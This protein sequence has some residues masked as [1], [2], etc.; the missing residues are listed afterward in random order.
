MSVI[1]KGKLKK[2]VEHHTR[3]FKDVMSGKLSHHETACYR[4]AKFKGR[5]SGEP[6]QNF[7]FPNSNEIDVLKFVDTQVK[8]GQR[9]TYVVYAYELVVGTKYRYESVVATGEGAVVQVTVAPSLKM[10]ETP[11]FSKNVLMIDSPPVHPDVEMVPYRAVNDRVRIQLNGNVGKYEMK[12]EKINEG[13]FVEEKKHL[14]AQ[15]K[16]L[17]E[18]IEY[19]GDDP[20]KAFQIWRMTKKPRKYSDFDGHLIKTVRTGDGYFHASS[21]T[22]VDKIEPNTK[23]YYTFRS[24][25]VHGNISY[26]TPIY[27]YEMIDDSG[28]VYPVMQVVPIS[29]TEQRQKSKAGKRFIRIYPSFGNT[30][31][32]L[33]ELDGVATAGDVRAVPLGIQE[34]KTWGKKFKIRIKSKNTGKQVDFNV[35]FEHKHV[36]D[37]KSV[38]GGR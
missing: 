3:S 15:S 19:Q 8:Y 13:D 30:L 29:L 12:P 7:Y 2:I 35:S 33:S 22:F 38:K 18:K 11:Y 17:G 14:M 6:I 27:E 20:P 23:Y 36:K 37:I 9:Y 21:A 25:D 1:L 34:E 16:I 4:V 31:P 28:S 5:P 26:P 24:V 10:V 32:E